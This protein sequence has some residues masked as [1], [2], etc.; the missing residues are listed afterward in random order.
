M[1]GIDKE[2]QGEGATHHF[3]CRCREEYFV[4]VELQLAEAKRIFERL[5]KGRGLIFSSAD[6]K[7]ALARIEQIGAPAESEK[8][9]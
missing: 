3:A 8:K 1:P 7:L 9:E 2:C 4:R 6:A 5:S